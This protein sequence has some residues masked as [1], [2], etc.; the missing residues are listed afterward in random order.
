[1]DHF[2]EIRSRLEHG[3]REDCRRRKGRRPTQVR[4]RAEEEVEREVWELGQRPLCGQGVAGVELQ[5]GSGR[6][7][8]LSSPTPRTR[9]RSTPQPP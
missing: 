7:P 6:S 3:E 1:M 4:C 2:W 8:C 5:Q 9:R